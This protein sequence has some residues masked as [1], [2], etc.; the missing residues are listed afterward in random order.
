[1]LSPVR[2]ALGVNERLTVFTVLTLLHAKRAEDRSVLIAV[3]MHANASLLGRATS[4]HPRARTSARARSLYRRCEAGAD[5]RSTEDE[6][7][8]W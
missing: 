7:S 1:M 6:D 3:V 5:N 2:A 8:R 4:A